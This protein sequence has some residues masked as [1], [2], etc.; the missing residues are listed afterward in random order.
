MFIVLEGIDGS[1]KGAHSKLLNR[2]M[3]EKGYDTFLTNEPTSGPIGRVLREALKKGS[4]DS[5]TEALLFAADRS[6]HVKEI[7]EKLRDG[8]IVITER[9]FYSSIAYQG[10]SGLSVDWTKEI[11]R[12]AP[13]PDLVLLLDLQADVA[14]KRISSK[15][16][17]RSSTRE[18]EYFEREEFLSKVRE[19][20]LDMEKENDN[21]TRIDASKDMEEVQTAIR[22][23]AGRLLSALAAEKKEPAQKDLGEYI[24]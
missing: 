12:F 4:L 9:Y 10:A 5:R 3:K 17:L 2:W 18:R 21:F 13:I 8:K 20:Y 23:R 7:S 14:M 1:G 19:V 11:N 6:E 16:S 24:G 22:K 15:N